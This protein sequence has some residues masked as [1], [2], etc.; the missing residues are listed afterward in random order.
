MSKQ[1][2]SNIIECLPDATFAIDCKGKVIVWNRA[3]EKM[4]G[5]IKDDIMGSIFLLNELM[6]NVVH[7]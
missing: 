4:T 3:I 5:T 7:V 2:L 1:L 6:E